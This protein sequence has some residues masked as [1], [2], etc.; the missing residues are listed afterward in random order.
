MLYPL[1]TNTRNAE[2]F[3]KLALAMPLAAALALTVV[4]TADAQ[5]RKAQHG[6]RA[7]MLMCQPVRPG[8]AG[9][10]L[11]APGGTAKT[12]TKWCTDCNGCDVYCCQGTTP[13]DIG[14]LA[15]EDDDE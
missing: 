10:G 8:Q 12:C 13:G 5:N 11:I 7:Q 2:M 3:K 9:G 1:T 14:V 4:A 15:I 6:A